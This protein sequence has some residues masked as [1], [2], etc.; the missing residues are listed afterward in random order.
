M[1]SSVLF[2]IHS[3]ERLRACSYSVVAPFCVLKN[4]H[5]VY[6]ICRRPRATLLLSIVTGKLF[7]LIIYGSLC[8]SLPRM[9]LL[10]L[11]GVCHLCQTA[12]Y[13]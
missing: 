4:H 13:L 9:I 5:A 8:H 7:L 10:F 12:K 3:E 2:G 6:A 1:R 11:N